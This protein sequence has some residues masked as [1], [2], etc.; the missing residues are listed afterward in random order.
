VEIFVFK[1]EV[2]NAALKMLGAEMGLFKIA[3][4]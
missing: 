2:A 1:G 4:T 3:R